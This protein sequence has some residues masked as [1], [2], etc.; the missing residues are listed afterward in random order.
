M[1]GEKRLRILC[2][3]FYVVYSC[4]LDTPLLSPGKSGGVSADEKTYGK[5]EE[6]GGLLSSGLEGSVS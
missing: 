5:A 4:P 2:S 6:E 3:A 1:Y